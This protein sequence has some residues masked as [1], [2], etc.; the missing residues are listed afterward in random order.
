MVRIRR[1]KKGFKKNKEKENIV[2]I[3]DK[4]LIIN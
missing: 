4:K 3:M 2:L 1:K